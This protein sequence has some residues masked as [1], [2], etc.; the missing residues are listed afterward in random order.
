MPSLV[1]LPESS[2]NS[3]KTGPSPDIFHTEG[4]RGRREE[5]VKRSCRRL[6]EEKGRSS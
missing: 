5:V 3:R 4:R 2:N 1:F 6:A